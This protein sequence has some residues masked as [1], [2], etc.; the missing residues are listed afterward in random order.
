VSADDADAGLD[1]PAIG[2]RLAWKP[3]DGYARYR[4]VLGTDSVIPCSVCGE[5]ADVVWFMGLPATPY[6][7][8]CYIDS[9]AERGDA[10]TGILAARDASGAWRP[11]QQGFDPRQP[12]GWRTD[13][14]DFD[15]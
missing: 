7:K 5:P 8:P 4:P 12:R 3:P 10:A 1:L 6:C 11:T 14:Y 2:L 13:P 15:W 9:G